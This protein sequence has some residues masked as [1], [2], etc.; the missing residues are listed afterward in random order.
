LPQA[1]AWVSA[2]EKPS[3]L[4]ST[5]TPFALWIVEAA[6]NLADGISN[7]ETRFGAGRVFPQFWLMDFK[8]QALRALLECQQLGLR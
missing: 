7:L 6:R 8:P 3:A 4:G 1:N 2:A 5:K